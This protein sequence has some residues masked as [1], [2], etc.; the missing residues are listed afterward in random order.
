MDGAGDPK[1]MCTRGL[2]I[3]LQILP[4]PHYYHNT[5]LLLW[6]H[7]CGK[8]G[9]CGTLELKLFTLVHYFVLKQIKKNEEGKSRVLKSPPSP[10]TGAFSVKGNKLCL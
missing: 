7:L 2:I 10:Y 6:Q 3:Q 1:V 4:R 9:N 5:L 8:F